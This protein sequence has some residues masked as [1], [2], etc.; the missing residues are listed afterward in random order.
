MP[1]PL[2]TFLIAYWI[3]WPV[4]LAVG[5]VRADLPKQRPLVYY[6]S[7]IDQRGAMVSSQHAALR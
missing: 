6:S 5:T 3:L 1:R 4:G 7:V 2:R